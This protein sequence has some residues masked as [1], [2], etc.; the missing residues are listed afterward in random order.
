MKNESP[1]KEQIALVKFADDC[2]SSGF[3]PAHYY[4]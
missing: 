4:R 3:M 1:T 2:E